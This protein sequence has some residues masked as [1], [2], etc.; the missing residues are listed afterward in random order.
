MF[1]FFTSGDKHLVLQN[2]LV[3]VMV[4]QRAHKCY[5]IGVVHT[6]K[7]QL[8]VVKTVLDQETMLAT[9]GESDR[10]QS[11]VAFAQ[12]N[13]EWGVQRLVSLNNYNRGVLG[14]H[15]VVE[16]G[17]M[18]NCL[19]DPGICGKAKSFADKSLPSGLL[20]QQGIL[21]VDGNFRDGKT[22]LLT[23]AAAGYLKAA[24]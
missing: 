2:D 13:Q 21:S 20:I 16:L 1:Q 4:P 17:E 9:P 7:E 11:L 12:P 15:N 3:L 22:R 10:L 19:L 6:I 8:L 14:I 18:T 5:F 23:Q 24:K